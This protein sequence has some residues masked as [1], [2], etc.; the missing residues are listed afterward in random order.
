M[1][2]PDR[3]HLTKDPGCKN[4][5]DLGTEPVTFDQTLHVAPK[6]RKNEKS[7]R[8]HL[9]NMLVRRCFAGGGGGGVKMRLLRTF[10]PT[11]NFLKLFQIFYWAVRSSTARSFIV[12]REVRSDRNQN[13][14][15]KRDFDISFVI[16]WLFSDFCPF[17]LHKKSCLPLNSGG[18]RSVVLA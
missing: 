6:W 4:F 7:M 1:A 17:D 16:S 15:K 11:W 18:H 12:R 14:S 13:F 9:P 8:P 10:I 2:L 3:I 5:N